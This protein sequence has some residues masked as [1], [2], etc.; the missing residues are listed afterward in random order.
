MEPPENE[1]GQ[2]AL[3]LDIEEVRVMFTSIVHRGGACN[4]TM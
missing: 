4:M 2:D 1:T 3:L